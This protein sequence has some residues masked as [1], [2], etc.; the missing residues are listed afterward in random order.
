MPSDPND[1]ALNFRDGTLTLRDGGG[2]SL[3]VPLE[4]GDVAITGLTPDM[5]EPTVYFSRGRRVAAR[6]GQDVEPQISLSTLLNRVTSRDATKPAVLDFLR[7][8]GV[9]ASNVRTNGIA[10]DLKTVDAELALN[11]PDGVSY[12][13]CHDVY[14]GHDINEGDPSTLSLSGPVWGGVDIDPPA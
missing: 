5:V 3:V 2:H 8:R 4:Q 6:K 11:T 13:V 9:Y 12:V 10:G 14:F 1:Y 7:F